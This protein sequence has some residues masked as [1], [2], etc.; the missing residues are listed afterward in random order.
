MTREEE[1]EL[2]DKILSDER[3]MDDMKED[4]RKLKESYNEQKGAEDEKSEEVKEHDVDEWE[5]LVNER[6][7]AYKER[8]EAISKF[9]DIKEKYIRRII[10][11]EKAMEMH[12]KDYN[13]DDFEDIPGKTKKEEIFEEEEIVK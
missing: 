9:K 13:S 8:D 6:D 2:L 1:K 5:Q 7:N 12:E 10:T 4:L 3:L 11:P